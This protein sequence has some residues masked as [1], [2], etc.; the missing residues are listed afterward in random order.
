MCFS[1]S[2]P[3]ALIVMAV[4]LLHPD[5][6]NLFEQRFKS[7]SDS[8]SKAERILTLNPIE[9]SRIKFPPNFHDN[10]NILKRAR[11]SYHLILNNCI[12]WSRTTTSPGIV[13]IAYEGTRDLFNRKVAGKILV[14]Q[15]T[16]F[17]VTGP[18]DN[19]EAKLILLDH[20][21]KQKRKAEYLE[22]RKST[23]PEDLKYERQRISEDVRHE[24][25]RRDEGRCTQ[26]RSVHKLEFDHIIP[27][28]RGG[29]NTVR[30]IQLLCEPCNR[31][32]SNSI[33]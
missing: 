18:Y 25:W 19:E 10:L 22:A 14:Y 20:L 30:N 23:P 28:S 6:H 7:H 2:P 9:R 1:K 26:C 32:K 33:G 27:V 29:S 21:K 24:V 15:N 3:F 17:A 31:S 11:D 5:A 8:I 12:F 13:D 16:F 4:R